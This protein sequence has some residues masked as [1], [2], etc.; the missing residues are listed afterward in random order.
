MLEIQVFQEQADSYGVNYR[1][2]LRGERR[3]FPGLSD[4]CQKQSR[5]EDQA[6]CT[7]LVIEANNENDVPCTYIAMYPSSYQRSTKCI[8]LWGSTKER[9]ATVHPLQLLLDT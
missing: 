5:Q 8:L 1:R 2:R 9:D 6:L 4:D 3:N 7:A